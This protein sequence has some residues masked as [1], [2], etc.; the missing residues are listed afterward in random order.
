MSDFNRLRRQ[1][2][3]KLIAD[4]AGQHARKVNDSLPRQW[5]IAE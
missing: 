3:L 4:H 2:A 5:S 1:R